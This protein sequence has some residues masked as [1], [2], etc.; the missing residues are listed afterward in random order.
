M[1]ED[2]KTNKIAV[3]KDLPTAIVRVAEDENTKEKYDLITMEDAMTEILEKVRE[4][5]K[6]TVGK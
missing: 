1:S 2:K 6:A 5:A 3:V 4:I